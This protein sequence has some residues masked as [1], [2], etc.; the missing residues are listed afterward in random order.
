MIEHMLGSMKRDKCY[1]I[2]TPLTVAI[3][4]LI[5]LDPDTLDD[6]EL[7]DAVVALRRQ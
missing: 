5:D 1:E 7:A 2:M 4:G 3:D 6:A